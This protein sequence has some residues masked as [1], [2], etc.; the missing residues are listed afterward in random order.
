M[1]Y[2][3]NYPVTI[4]GTKP[5]PTS[6]ITA[7]IH[8]NEHA[9][10]VALEKM[11]AQ[12]ITIEAGTV[13]IE[14]GHLEAIE[15]NTRGDKPNNL[16]RLFR[17]EGELSDDEKRGTAFPRSR[18]LMKLFGDADALLDIHTSRN[19]NCPRFIICEKNSLETAENLPFEMVLTGINAFEKGAT[20][21][22]MDSLGKIA[23]CIEC[24]QHDDP[25]AVDL[26]ILA[27]EQF[28]VAMNHKEGH[29]S[30]LHQKRLE[31][32]YLYTSKTDK[33]VFYGTFREFE[34]VTK[35]QLI[36]HDGDEAVTAPEDGFIV[37]PVVRNAVD[38]EC[39]LLAKEVK[40]KSEDE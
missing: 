35:D 9:G 32:F 25:K 2:K 13:I 11:L 34:P 26:A 37:F 19:E 33:F 31:I 40:E 7:G 38:E 30:V 22:Y 6:V 36:G 5:G 20:D 12:G 15:A 21:G 10:I 27:I 23:L 4:H 24:G 17:P 1:I 28:L 14:L 16:N 18:Y 39:F 29:V 8:G 3:Q